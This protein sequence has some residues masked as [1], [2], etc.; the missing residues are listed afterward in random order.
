MADFD[1]TKQKLGMDEM[2]KRER[3]EIFE[4]FVDGGGKVV[5][6]KKKKGVSFDRTKQ[7]EWMGK[8]ADSKER[9]GEGFIDSDY[10]SSMDDIGPDKEERKWASFWDSIAVRF[11]GL[12]SKTVA[13]FGN[14]V[15][16]NF[17]EFIKSRV[18]PQMNNF[19]SIIN[20]IMTTDEKKFEEIKS[21]LNEKEPYYYPL[22]LKY[23]ELYVKDE[24][25]LLMYYR[26]AGIKKITP[27]H[28]EEPLKIIMY[29]IYL[30]KDFKTGAINAFRTALFIIAKHKNWNKA[31]Y[32]REMTQVRNTINII[33]SQLLPKFYSII[34][35]NIK[36]NVYLD[37]KRMTR[38][39]GIQDEDRIDYAAKK[40]S[41]LEEMLPQVS[42]GKDDKGTEEKKEELKYIKKYFYEL[43]E[44]DIKNM[45]LDE[46]IIKG[47]KLMQETDWKANIEEQ[48]SEFPVDKCSEN[49]K[50]LHILAFLKEFENEYSFILTSPK[51]NVQSLYE[52]NIRV[53]YK[54]KLNDM[55]TPLSGLY[56]TIHNYM[57]V[58]KSIDDVNDDPAMQEYDKYNRVTKYEGKKE[59]ISLGLRKRILSYFAELQQYFDKFIDD[60]NGEQKI[61]GTP[62]EK[63]RFDKDV[64]GNRKAE[65]KTVIET[66]SMADAFITAFIFRLEES[67]DFSGTGI[68]I[69]QYDVEAEGESKE[70][71]EMSFLD[72]IAD[73]IEND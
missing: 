56:E 32:R 38:Y 37:S 12:F 8:I 20:Y 43:N 45:E 23:S 39:L 65:G 30:L 46:F 66:I 57:E 41:E 24:F 55:Y 13:F 68:E 15:N 40:A 6:E 34:L 27:R 63:L 60:Y 2:D 9:T 44:E 69:K 35:Y 18:I 70:S 28:L 49:D 10:D 52:D 61:I 59:E 33:F 5:D 53:D 51:V 64:E 22:L 21:A 26:R 50:I 62:D 3:K 14:R 36:E 25:S 11:K 54:D 17:F 1:D 7:K 71:G 31:V 72:E 48:K 58:V 29:K 16:E 73:S 4:K 19:N 47:I 67:G 42:K